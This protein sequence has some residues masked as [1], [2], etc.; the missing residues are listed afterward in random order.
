MKPSFVP[1]GAER[2]TGTVHPFAET[3]E[4]ETRRVRRSGGPIR[5]LRPV[6]RHT[7]VQFPCS[8][9][10]LIRTCRAL[11]WRTTFVRLSC[12]MR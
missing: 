7:Y 5:R 10:T 11:E 3:G 2:P 1:S 4:P 8:R 6:I 9:A 12:T